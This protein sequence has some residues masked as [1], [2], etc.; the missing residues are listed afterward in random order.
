MGYL[1]QFWSFFTSH[2]PSLAAIGVV[3]SG[4]FAFIK[5]YDLRN[6]E[7]RQ[8]NW[9]DYQ[10]ALETVW[11]RTTSGG[12]VASSRQIAAVYRL[13]RFK[14]FYFATVTA[15]EDAGARNPDSW[16]QNVGPHAK[17]V[18]SALKKTWSYWWQSRK[19][20]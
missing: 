4:L 15:L 6:R 7:L 13:V 19:F 9:S 18:T 2:F 3:A 10:E 11:G 16:K 17:K 20:S 12:D 1:S 14:E 5:W 8:R